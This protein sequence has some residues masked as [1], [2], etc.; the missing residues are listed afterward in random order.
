[1][2]LEVKTRQN[3]RVNL[4]LSLVTSQTKVVTRDRTFYLIHFQGGQTME[5]CSEL[6]DIPL[7][8][9]DLRPKSPS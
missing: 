2:R 6:P 7:Q 4:D 5:A 9:K 8:E 3:V 1:M